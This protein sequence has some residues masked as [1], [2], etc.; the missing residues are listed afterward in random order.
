MVMWRHQDNWKLKIKQDLKINVQKNEGAIK[1]GQSL[2]MDQFMCVVITILNLNF[3]FYFYFY[4]H[5]FAQES[6]RYQLLSIHMW[7]G[8]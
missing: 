4:I 3:Y 7:K 8:V 6:K 5:C 1:N 2:K